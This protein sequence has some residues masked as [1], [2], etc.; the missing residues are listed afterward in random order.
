MSVVLAAEDGDALG[1]TD[2][3]GAAEGAGVGEFVGSKTVVSSMLH[4]RIVTRNTTIMD[5]AL[6]VIT[7]NSNNLA[8]RARM[9]IS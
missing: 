2:V 8:W 3:L 7:I 5:T 6:I 9:V 4:K 1:S